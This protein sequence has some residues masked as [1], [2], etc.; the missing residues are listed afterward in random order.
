MSFGI[1]EGMAMGAP[2]ASRT[3]LEATEALRDGG[4]IRDQGTRGAGALSRRFTLSA[5]HGGKGFEI[6]VRVS[7]PRQRREDLT[8]QAHAAPADAAAI[9]CLV[10]PISRAGNPATPGR[11]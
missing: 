10:W 8:E 11:P 5:G 4:E 9:E 2:L 7:F 1:S 3:G 6:V